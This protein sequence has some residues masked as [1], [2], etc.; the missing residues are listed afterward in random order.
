MSFISSNFLLLIMPVWEAAVHLY[1]HMN[2]RYPKTFF[3]I[4]NTWNFWDKLMEMW[5]LNNSESDL[6]KKVFEDKLTYF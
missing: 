1:V 3:L 6:E 2:F 4:G 5:V